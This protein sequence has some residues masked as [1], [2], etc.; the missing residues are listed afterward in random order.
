MINY[1]VEKS[2]AE[3]IQAKLNEQNRLLIAEIKYKH[4]LEKSLKE[5][6]LK[7]LQHQINPHFLFNV[8]N[9]V[10][11][12]IYLKDYQKAQS[13]LKAF[14]K[15]LRYSVND[16]ENVVTLE[17][18]LDYIKKYLYI[19]NLRFGDRIT[20]QLNIDPTTLN[21]EIPC[22]TLQPLV[23]NSI[24]HGLEPKIT[25]GVLVITTTSY[26]NNI[27]ITI[28]D[29]GIGMTKDTLLNLN[30]P[31]PETSKQSIGLRNVKQRLSL[32]FGEDCSLKIQSE[33]DKGTKI[34]LTIPKDRKSLKNGLIMA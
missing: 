5:A 7:A 14:T 11:R 12:L 30:S 20:Y 16:F 23:E 32:F 17:Q 19:Q 8:L 10:D 21:I 18:E 34:T 28:E 25:G 1:I 22:F 6:E 24:I 3:S 29:N 15:M 31:P 26:D 33:T 4:K 9:M 13:V 2:I 27:Q